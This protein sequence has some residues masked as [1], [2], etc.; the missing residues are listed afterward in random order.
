MAGTRQRE[1]IA[2][3]FLDNYYGGSVHFHGMMGS[4]PALAGADGVRRYQAAGVADRCLRLLG[5]DLLVRSRRFACDVPPLQGWVSANN[6][7]LRG[8]DV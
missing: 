4:G 2:R 6:G 5:E 7:I 3:E 1:A 8:I